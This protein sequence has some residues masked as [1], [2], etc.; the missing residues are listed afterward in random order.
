[1]TKEQKEACWRNSSKACSTC[2]ECK[3][4]EDID[5]LERM[6]KLMQTTDNIGVLNRMYERCGNALSKI[7][8]ENYNR[9]KQKNQKFSDEKLEKVWNEILS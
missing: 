7:F 8:D 4:E 6:I 5:T 9:I 2:N 1:M 3:Y